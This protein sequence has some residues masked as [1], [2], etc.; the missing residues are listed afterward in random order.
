MF[1]LNLKKVV[2]YHFTSLLIFTTCVRVV[3]KS[4]K[5]TTIGVRANL[6]PGWLSHLCPR[7]ILTVCKKNCIMLHLQNCV[8]W[9]SPAKSCWEKSRISGTYYRWT[10]WIPFFFW[11][12]INTFFTFGCWLLP[13]NLAFARKMM[14]LPHSGDGG[15]WLVLTTSHIVESRLTGSKELLNITFLLH[16]KF[17]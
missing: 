1:C 16:R 12:L 8:A 4:V 3:T 11:R 14:A 5:L 10:E 15:L 17:K 9:P 7:N 2:T 13:E 6:F